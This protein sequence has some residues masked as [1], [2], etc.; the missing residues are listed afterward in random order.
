MAKIQAA[1]TEEITKDMITKSKDVLKWFKITLIPLCLT[2]FAVVVISGCASM[3]AK[4]EL[5][6]FNTL[7]SSGQY[8]DAANLELK[9][10][11]DEKSDPSHLLQMLQAGAA[12]RYAR[13]YPQSTELF[14]ECEDVIKYFNEQL[15]TNDV[16]SA[17]VSVLVNDASLDYRGEEYDGV[18]VNTYKALNFWKIGKNDLARIEFNRA[19]DRQRRAKERFAEEI[20]K[21]NEE[22][23][24]EQ[25]EENR[26]AEQNK[27][28]KM[29]I[30]KAV[31]NPEID[32][33][34][35]KKYSNLYAFKAYPDFINPFTTY[36]AGLFFLSEGDYA[37]AATLLKETYG[38]VEENPVVADDFATVE[39]ILD[40]KRA[41]GYYTWIIFENGL[42]P[43][44][45]E[46][47]VDLPIFFVTDRV[48]YAGIALPKLKF[49][50]QAF[51]YLVV[52]N[53]GKETAKTRA[54]ASMDRVIQ[55]EFKMRYPLIVTRAVISMLMK[56]YT[57]YLAQ[58]HFGNIGGLLAAVYQL[59]TTAADIR[60]WTALPKEFQVAKIVTPEGGSVTIATPDGKAY[61]VSVPKKKNSLIYVKIPSRGARVV[62]DV[63]EL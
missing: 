13:K 6:A 50:S 24:K 46:F 57:Q 54:L 59:A 29:D 14:D 17:I 63:M 62:I 42:G 53:A 25:I 9:E 45:E 15:F 11:G 60:M 61:N 16:G 44:K 19:L 22:I 40:R 39:K 2:C 20:S 47:R 55:T 12:L 49:R 48:K 27:A 38:M 28:P 52:R 32:N 30:D 10:K 7:Y 31:N 58:K 18:M 23:S 3:S 35:K 26:K 37:K 21:M 5:S 1:Y 4:K 34:L 8:L 51:P 36:M 41:E 43:E 56:T 33:I